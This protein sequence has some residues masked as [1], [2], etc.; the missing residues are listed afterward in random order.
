MDF[1]PCENHY[2]FLLYY[3]KHVVVIILCLVQFISARS[4]H[5]FLLR[6]YQ[7]AFQVSHVVPVNTDV[8]LLLEK[9]ANQACLLRSNQQ[10]Q[11]DI[12]LLRKFYLWLIIITFTS[13]LYF[14]MILF[15]PKY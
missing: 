1:S 10:V 7:P 9:K 3:L 8:V 14:M 4:C 15:I 12:F 13:I 6:I 11:G 2:Q 5:C